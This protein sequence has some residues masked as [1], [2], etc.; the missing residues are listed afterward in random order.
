MTQLIQHTND[1]HDEDLKIHRQGFSSEA[2]FK[3]WKEKVEKET[4]SWF[5][6]YRKREGKN[7]II[8]WYRCNRSGTYRP[9]GTGKR[10][11]K[12]QGSSKIGGHCTA[13]MKTISSK[14]RGNVVVEACLG[15]TGHEKKLGH[16]RIP[17]QLRQEIAG[18]LAKGV[19]IESIL[20]EIRNNAGGG[21]FRDHLVDRKDIINVKHQLNV[22]LMEK[23]SKDTKSVDFWVNELQNGTFNPVLVYKPQ[24]VNEYSLPAEDFLLGIQTKYQLDMLKKYGRKIICMDSTHKT[25]QYDFQLISVLV[26]DEFGEGVPV[27]WLISNREDQLVLSPFLAAM[28]TK[29]GNMETEV[30]MSDDANNFYNAWVLN[31]PRPSKKLIC[32]WHVDKNWRKGLKSH[33]STT[34]DMAVVYAAL[35]TMQFEEDEAKFR[36]QL[37][38][39]CGWC[40][41]TYPRFYS[42]FFPTYVKHVEQW[43]LCFRIDAG[44][45]TNMATEAF[46]NILKGLYFQKKQNR[47]IDHLLCQ[48]LKIARDKV[49]DG[50]IKSEKGKRTYKM[51]ATDERHKS[52]AQIKE[53]DV[54]K[55]DRGNWRVRSQE[56]DSRSYCVSSIEDT[57][58]CIIRCSK[59]SV[60]KH[61]YRCGCIDFNVRGI[62]CKHIHAVHIRQL[63]CNE[64][65]STK[66]VKTKLNVDSEES[67]NVKYFQEILRDNSE[68]PG[69]IFNLASVRVAML[70][71]IAEL[72][73]I[74]QSSTSPQALRTAMAHVKSAITVAQGLGR[75][76]NEHAYDL[77]PKGYIPPNKKFDIQQ[78]FIK[79]RKAYKKPQNSLSFPTTEQRKDVKMKLA[80]QVP[81]ICAFCFQEN[82][83]KND[84]EVQ[85]VECP[86]CGLWAH[87]QCD[88]KDTSTND[89]ICSICAS[90]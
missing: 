55:V 27:A 4:I 46:H 14:D 2:E 76:D 33:I 23:D 16:L 38:E 62:A 49:F 39:F 73:D 67:E 66:K 71:K 48:L 81:F 7:S 43:A 13:F 69:L 17:D 10:A 6:K 84:Q 41:K 68:E 40:E 35:K 1:T 79:T 29:C 45:N 26:I 78:R 87:R 77:K 88:C 54:I 3:Q 85:W 20:D 57:C 18:K 31:F 24:G 32:A 58:N 44:I 51:R 25:N 80:D 37:Q 19:K 83:E 28:A 53:Q 12:Q 65:P 72:T 61:M 89:Y 21:I 74:V 47:R 56:D 30:F 22:D 63:N 52:A 42:Y 64:E 60:C 70:A 15:H 11:M 86:R 36:K 90:V 82:D 59:C 5:V 9:R 34:D 50:L 75:L 8:D